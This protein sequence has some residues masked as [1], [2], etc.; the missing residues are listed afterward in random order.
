[1]YTFVQVAWFARTFFLGSLSV[2]TTST[3]SSILSSRNPPSKA[4]A[5]YAISHCGD[6]IEGK[7]VTAVD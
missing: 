2:S 4:V 7:L 6:S 1:V 3:R 5:R